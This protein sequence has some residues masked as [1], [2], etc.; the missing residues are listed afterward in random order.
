MK[1]KLDISFMVFILILLLYV[2]FTLPFIISNPIEK[3]YGCYIYHVQECL[4]CHSSN[5]TYSLCSGFC[6][7]PRE[8]DLDNSSLSQVCIIHKIEQ[9]YLPI[10][11]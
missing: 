6:F 8:M 11:W 5:L 9:G 7:E 4:N 2:I 1:N 10:Y 3:N